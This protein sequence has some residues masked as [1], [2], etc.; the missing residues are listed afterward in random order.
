MFSRLGQQ[1]EPGPESVPAVKKSRKRELAFLWVGLAAVSAAVAFLLTPGLYSSG[2]LPT[3]DS[4][5]DKIASESIKAPR[6]YTIPD[7]EQTELKRDEAERAVRSVYNFDSN[8]SDELND[9]IHRAFAHVRALFEPDPSVA[10]EPAG[11]SGDPVNESEMDMAMG[12]RP[13]PAPVRPP[14][15]DPAAPP[16]RPADKAGE[17]AAPANGKPAVEAPAGPDPTVLAAV[18]AE[19]PRFFSILRMAPN[20]RVWKAL[21]DERFSLAVEKAAVDLLKRAMSQDLSEDATRRIEDTGRLVTI[22]RL[23]NGEIFEE[24]NIKSDLVRD[25]V[26]A[27]RQLQEAPVAELEGLAPELQYA[28]RAIVSQVIVPNTSFNAMETTQRKR[29][30][31]DAVRPLTVSVKKGEVVIREGE[32]FEPRH[33]MILKGIASVTREQSRTQAFLGSFCAVGLFIGVS[34]LFARRNIRKFRVSPRDVVYL[35]VA[36]LGTLLFG[37]LWMSVAPALRDHLPDASN[38]TLYY[39]FPVA[40]GAMMTRMVLNSEVA[41]IYSLIASVLFGMMAE[42]SFPM[43]MF[44]AVSSLLCAHGVGKV[45]QRST[46]MKAGVHGGLASAGIVLAMSLMDGK[47]TS[48]SALSSGV[49]A[50]A[51]GPISA[52]IVLTMSYLVE[53]VFGYTTNI[54]LLELANL[55]HP[56]LKELILQAPGTYHHSIIVGSLVEAGAEAIGCN[57]LLARVMAYYH[58]IGK[59]KNPEYFAENQKGG[60]NRHDKLSP[61]MSALVIKAHVKD[62]MEMARQ[63]KLPDPIIAAIEQHH[64]N[65]LIRYFYHKARQQEAPDNPVREDDFRYP[66]RKPQFR[67]SALCMLADGIEAAARSIPDPTPARLQGLVQTMINRLFSSG[68]LDECDLTLR[69]L[70]KIAEAYTRVLTGMYH[71]RPRYPQQPAKVRARASGSSPQAENNESTPRPAADEHHSSEPVAAPAASSPYAA[72]KSPSGS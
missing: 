17:K 34:F 37:R 29:Q 31:R 54:R 58:D 68:Q 26:E 11:E 47:F 16:P 40:A 7:E 61:H 18:D 41:I 20:E 32:R 35:S 57:P 52:M 48:P 60:L 5:L 53:D 55:N 12:G 22:Q 4:F 33:L 21:R 39:L 65:T 30:A 59:A 49:M 27:R 64:G 72:A 43:M 46:I 51:S 9:R 15:A 62:G 71:H 25:I 50:F 70:H 24:E 19:K 10:G 63:H 45:K 38:V 44:A 66:G 56:V 23:R 67:E 8:I 13:A 14:Y 2:A 36:L 1:I 6:D 42:N 3:S 69:D 28:I